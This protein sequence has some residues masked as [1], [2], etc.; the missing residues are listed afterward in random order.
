MRRRRDPAA[1]TRSRFWSHGAQQRWCAVM[2]WAVFPS[3]PNGPQTT[4]WFRS[5]TPAGPSHT[6]CPS[7]A[8][9]A[10]PCLQEE[11]AGWQAGV[12][13]CSAGMTECPYEVLLCSSSCIICC[14]LGWHKQL[15]CMCDF[16]CVHSSISTPL[17]YAFL[18]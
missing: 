11:L 3:G 12:P 18:G 16:V 9:H 14:A 6:L 13:P 5:F 10:C 1:P 15:L 4:D 17:L 8:D 2:I 7:P